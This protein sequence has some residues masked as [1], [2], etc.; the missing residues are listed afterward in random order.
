MTLSSTAGPRNLPKGKQIPLKIF[1]PPKNTKFIHG[2]PLKKSKQKR[3]SDSKQK[4]FIYY[5]FLTIMNV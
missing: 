3:L 2:N 5:Y 1:L 4:K